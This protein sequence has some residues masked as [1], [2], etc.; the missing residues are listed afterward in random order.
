M[1]QKELPFFR[2]LIPFSAYSEGWA[3]YAERLAWE[4]GFE[5]DPYDDVG[6]LQAELFR[7]VRLVVDT[8]IHYSRW[9]REEAIDYMLANTGMAESDVMAELGDAFDLSDFHRVVLTNGS[10]PLTMLEDLVDDYI[11]AKKA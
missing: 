7:S 3:L 6:R 1:E 9:S 2:R 10:M 11:A 5:D 4:M 8:G